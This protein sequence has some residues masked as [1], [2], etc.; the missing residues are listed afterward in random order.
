MVPSPVRH[1]EPVAVLAARLST[2]DG[3]LDLKQSRF[4][5]HRLLVADLS[6]GPGRGFQAAR[7]LFVQLGL[8]WPEAKS[9]QLK[10][11]DRLSYAGLIAQGID[12]EARGDAVVL[13][14]L[15]AARQI[16]SALGA[17]KS[18]LIVLA[19]R[20]S[21]DWHAED[22]W[23][24]RFLI[25]ARDGLDGTLIV[26]PSAGDPNLP[27]CLQPN[28]LAPPQHEAIDDKKSE[29]P[30]VALVPGVVSAEVLELLAADES[31]GI[32][33]SGGARLVPFE[34]RQLPSPR[35]AARHD[36][37][38]QIA[39]DISWLKAYAHLHGQNLFADCG[40]LSQEAWL[41]Y[42]EGGGSHAIRLMKR[43]WDCAR[44][45]NERGQIEVQLQGMRIALHRFAEADAAP[46]ANPALPPQLR[47]FLQMTRGW[48][49]VMAGKP[50]DGYRLLNDLRLSTEGD[51]VGPETLYLFNILALSLSRIGR[52]DEAVALERQIEQANSA[53]DARDWQLHYVNAINMARLF[54]MQGDLD[55]AQRYY[56]AAFATCDGGRSASDLI[57]RNA[58]LGR[59]AEHRK[60]IEA[61]RQAW[62][63]AAL[64]FVACDAPEA[65]S[66]RCAR[67]IVTQQHRHL[68][69]VEALAASLSEHLAAV[70][71]LPPQSGELPDRQAA[72]VSDAPV[73]ARW[74][75]S[76]QADEIVGG[77]GWSVV[78]SSQAVVQAFD[79]PAHRILRRRLNDIIRR[80]PGAA[81]LTHAACW[82]VDDRCGREMPVDARE[83]AEAG[84][85]CGV[86]WTTYGNSGVELG[87]NIRD[88][89]ERESLLRVG[90]L[91]AR[92][93]PQDISMRIEF[94][95][96]LGTLVVHDRYGLIAA[97][98]AGATLASVL[99]RFPAADAASIRDEARRLEQARIICLD[100]PHNWA[101]ALL[102]RRGIA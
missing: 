93:V 85:R 25:A 11:K 52:A 23:L 19:P 47:Q 101:T 27:S 61:A 12:S 18:V 76:M 29:V 48:A 56:D 67:M 51:A 20:F 78:S 49:A 42:A 86:G 40:A 99:R 31:F 82:L 58:C 36:R 15:D 68:D 87:P 60:D 54:R 28:W 64:H 43:A 45:L 32:P 14:A 53:L 81:R 71:G 2:T 39:A 97:A 7:D 74:Q 35:L 9:S 59:L 26:C 1:P 79:G 17:V 55:L 10:H 77:P 30:L 90:A 4:G 89:L 102:E 44:S 98:A 62:L 21:N 84:I 83:Q 63:R 91:V 94:R 66:D 72:D 69:P 50:A 3:L 6:L 8:P 34:M 5:Q 13:R 22:I 80:S 88:R 37:L 24:L 100:L 65:I 46:D 16:L 70:S 33:L 95:R 92:C 57:Y 38:S 73:F 96:Y 41:Q 75:D